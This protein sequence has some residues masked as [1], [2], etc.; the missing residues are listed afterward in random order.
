[1]QFL[2]YIKLYPSTKLD[3][4]PR[5]RQNFKIIILCTEI[6]EINFS[7]NLKLNSKISNKN[8]NLFFICEHIFLRN[9]YSNIVSKQT[10]TI[11]YKKHIFD[12]LSIASPFKSFW[13][14]KKVKKC[15]D[16]GAGGG[17]PGLVLAIF[18]PQIFISMLDSIQRKT[19]FHNGIFSILWIKNCNSICS[20]GEHIIFSISHRKKY[21]V[22]TSRA[23]AELENLLEL[24][25]YITN[26]Y[27]KF[28]AMKRIKGCSKEL[29]STHNLS[30]KLDFKIKSIIKI[31]KRYSGKVLIVY[32]KIN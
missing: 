4:Y 1:M 25:V 32:K 13:F 31:D 15:V 24:F 18:F 16:F 27:A 5:F 28:I 2:P 9:S 19:N 10:S 23:V 29:N 26:S 20:R 21:D 22:V 17:F 12:S 3:S 7:N 14:N 11:L 8:R 30:I 6:S